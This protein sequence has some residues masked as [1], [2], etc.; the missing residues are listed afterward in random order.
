MRS[1]SIADAGPAGNQPAICDGGKIGAATGIWWH[2]D[3]RRRNV[4]S[5]G[6]FVYC[7]ALWRTRFGGL[8]TEDMGRGTCRYD[9]NV[10]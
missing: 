4:R 6:Q 1:S 3:L 5:G 8:E 7:D 10:G 2:V 9:H